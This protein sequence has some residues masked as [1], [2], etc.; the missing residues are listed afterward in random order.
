MKIETTAR[1]VLDEDDMRKLRDALNG[2]GTG[3]FEPEIV[4]FGTRLIAMINEA[5]SHE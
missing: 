2:T 5:L 4:A 3:D 1:L